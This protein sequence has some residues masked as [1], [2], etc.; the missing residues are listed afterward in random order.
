MSRDRIALIHGVGLDGSM[1]GPL[2]EFLEPEYDVQVLEL[3]GPREPAKGS[4]RGNAGRARG[5]RR[6]TARAG[7][8]PGGLLAGRPR[9]PARGQVP[10]R[11]GRQPGVGGLGLRTHLRGARRRHGAARL[12]GIGFPGNRGGIDPPLVSGRVRRAGGDGQS[13]P[14]GPAEERPEVLPGLLPR[15]RHGRRGNR[16]RTAPDHRS[17][18]RRDRRAGPRVNARDERAAG[19]GPSPAAPT[20]SSAAPAT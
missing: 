20:P 11:P 1:W 10:A 9:G 19:R 2:R 16:R 12:G 6:R 5:G 17:F 8:S 13:D 3:L 14:R 18:P 7:Y 4:R 15:V